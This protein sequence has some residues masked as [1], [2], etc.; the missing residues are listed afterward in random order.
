MG[1]YYPLLVFHSC[2][3]WLVLGSIALS[4]YRAYRGWKGKKLFSR[5]DNSIRHITATIAHIQLLIGIS[6]YF[7]SPLIKYFLGD[8]GK[9]VHDRQ[10]RFF[11]MEHS[12]MMLVGITILTIGSA[13]AKRKTTDNEKHRTVAIWY[14]VAL[15]VIL[16][17]VPWAFS[18]LVS[19]PWVRWF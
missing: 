1:A 12:L 5:T 7:I 2:F 4:L 17:S 19:R 15:L 18:P 6:L 14:T 3:R 16:S 9:A 8:F 10:I 13:K 11:G